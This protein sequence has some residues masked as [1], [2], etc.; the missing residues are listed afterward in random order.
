MIVALEEVMVMSLAILELDRRYLRLI[1]CGTV[2]DITTMS[3][4]EQLP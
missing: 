2:E 4:I 3:F 1:R